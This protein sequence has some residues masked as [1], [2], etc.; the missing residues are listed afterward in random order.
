MMNGSPLQHRS[1]E[2]GRKD[3]SVTQGENAETREPAGDTYTQHVKA[4]CRTNSAAEELKNADRT[5]PSRHRSQNC[6][7]QKD[8]NSTRQREGGPLGTIV[9]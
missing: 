7:T 6:S 5:E 1:T 2:E 9:P 3:G 4:S 8:G